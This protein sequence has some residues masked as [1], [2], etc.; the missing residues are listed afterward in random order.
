MLRFLRISCCSPCRESRTTTFV[1]LAR[2]FVHPAVFRRICFLF[3]TVLDL[4]FALHMQWKCPACETPIEHRRADDLHDAS[5]VYRCPVC[6]LE[7]TFEPKTQKMILAPLHLDEDETP[8]SKSR[9]T[10]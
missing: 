2:S 9:R 6:R 8:P 5:R 7:L 10:A 1:T 4:C 3:F